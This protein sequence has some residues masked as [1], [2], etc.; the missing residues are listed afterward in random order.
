VGDKALF[1]KQT[2]DRWISLSA[3]AIALCALLFS[4]YQGYLVRDH[5]RKSVRPLI[6]IGGLHDEKGSGFRIGN[7]GLGP[8]IIQWFEVTVNGKPVK[9]WM[10]FYEAV[11]LPGT[12][13]ARYLNPT[14]AT[15]IRPGR[16][17][18]LFWVSPGP[19]DNTLRTTKAV[20]TMRLCYCS[21]YDECWLASG[22]LHTPPYQTCPVKP[23]VTFLK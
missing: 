19:A 15:V 18:D 3:A 1:K 7:E 16:S 8:G 23:A 10:E 2:P 11:G 14:Q 9:N 12:F 4:F 17:E 13:S 22:G 5:N 20:I 21:I 6:V